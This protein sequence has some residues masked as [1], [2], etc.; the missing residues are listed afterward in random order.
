MLR[1]S[2]GGGA[3]A[4]VPAA[5]VMAPDLVPGQCWLVNCGR[6]AI[7]DLHAAAADECLELLE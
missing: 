1:E 3:V 6:C 5:G 4:Q 7:E 2:T